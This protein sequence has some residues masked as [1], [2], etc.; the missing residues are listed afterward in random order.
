MNTYFEFTELKAGDHFRFAG[1]D[2]LFF[3]VD[4]TKAKCCGAFGRGL[5]RLGKTGETV[6]VG[7]NVGGLILVVSN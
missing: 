2:D 1:Y 4:S 7:P 6:E 3:K 5:T